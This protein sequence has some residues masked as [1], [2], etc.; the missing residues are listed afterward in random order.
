MARAVEL[1]SRSVERGLVERRVS[2]NDR[3]EVLLQITPRGE[4][5]LRSLT[6]AH[7][8]EIES[9]AP[10]LLSALDALLGD[11]HRLR[12]LPK[13]GVEPRARTSTKR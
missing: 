4:R 11:G 8:S 6:V 12:R 1:V 13:T 7:R 5:V 2:K 9:A 3:R 10:L